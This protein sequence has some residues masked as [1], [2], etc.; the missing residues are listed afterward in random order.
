MRLI[1]QKL[2]HFG[3]YL[4][5]HSQLQECLRM[6]KYGP[7]KTWRYLFMQGFRLPLQFN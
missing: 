6:M 1:A 5:M 3:E 2:R 7:Q 4:A